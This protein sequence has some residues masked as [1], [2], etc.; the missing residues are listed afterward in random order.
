[1]LFRPSWAVLCS[2]SGIKTVPYFFDS[3]IFEACLISILDVLFLEMMAVFFDQLR[4]KW[5]CS[6]QL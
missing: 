3:D 1:M 5:P 4:S 6:P 2:L